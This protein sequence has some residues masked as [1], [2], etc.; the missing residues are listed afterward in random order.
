MNCLEFRR[1]VLVDPRSIGEEARAHASECVACRETLGKQ[2]EADD[3]LFA[4]LQVPVPDG[5]ADRILVARGHRPA[6]R[7]WTFG[8][9]AAR[10]FSAAATLR[11]IRS[12]T[13]RSTTSRT[14]RNRSRRFMQSA[15]TTCRWCSRS[16]D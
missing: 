2:R 3:Q 4:A 10:E 12:A 1:L 8:I 7:R 9:A 13:R 15:T 6:R 14:S 5:L 16:R 11:T